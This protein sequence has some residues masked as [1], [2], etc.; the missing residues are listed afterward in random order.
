M[1]MAFDPFSDF[2]YSTHIVVTY[3]GTL[4]VRLI[5]NTYALRFS[6]IWY[7]SQGLYGSGA[8]VLSAKGLTRRI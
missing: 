6:L 8:A 3:E 2:L 7:E 1:S 5:C 4:V